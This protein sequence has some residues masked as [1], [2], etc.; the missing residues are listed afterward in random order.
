MA[1][2]QRHEYYTT[3][4]T[5][6][7]PLDLHE[8]QLAIF[9]A[10]AYSP[11][12]AVRQAY[13]EAA[14][15]A[16]DIGMKALEASGVTEIDTSKELSQKTPN[17]LVGALTKRELEMLDYISTGLPNSEI[18]RLA[19]VTEQTV[20]FH[21]SSIYRKLGVKSRTEAAQLAAQA[22][23]INDTDLEIAAS[24]FY[25]LTKR[26]KEVLAAVARGLSNRQ[27]ANEFSVKEQ[28][29]KFHLANIF[30]K[31]NVKTRTEA[32]NLLAAQVDDRDLEVNLDI[33]LNPQRRLA[34][35]AASLLS[36][37][38]LVIK[39]LG[40]FPEDEP[41]RTSTGENTLMHEVEP[42]EAAEAEAPDTHT[43][44]V[45]PIRPEQN[46]APLTDEAPPE[47][48]ESAVPSSSKLTQRVPPVRRKQSATKEYAS[49]PPPGVILDEHGIPYE[50][51]SVYDRSFQLMHKAKYEEYDDGGYFHGEDLSVADIGDPW[52]GPFRN[53]VK[54]T[55][56]RLRALNLLNGYA[57]MD[58]QGLNGASFNTLRRLMH[59]SVITQEQFDARML[60]ID[61]VVAL[62]VFPNS[63]NILRNGATQRQAKRIIKQEVD[64]NIA[65][66]EAA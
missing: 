18:A 41:P 57:M 32:L 61:S 23:G 15:V 19:F 65:E 45:I 17:S 50:S 10:D 6:I 11:E 24:R 3:Y 34:L 13:I 43:A 39:K 48:A 40:E 60:D 1:T 16:V 63:W 58:L 51:K 20:K 27:A 44:P 25:D 54:D 31:L 66:Q 59:E 30:Q 62:L 4:T 21:L 46:P 26:E 7:E 52:E 14:L 22:K 36:K 5:P 42:K 38:S 12:R 2:P 28:T 49:T 9:E 33:P 47:S 8:G 53:R 37:A 64:A 55:M 56:Q 35:E 29:V